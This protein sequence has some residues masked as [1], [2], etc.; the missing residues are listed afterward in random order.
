MAY[1]APTARRVAFGRTLGSPPP[2]GTPPPGP[3]VFTPLRIGEVPPGDPVPFPGSSRQF[4]ELRIDVPSG[5]AFA[6]VGATPSL[7]NIG[8]VYFPGVVDGNVAQI[9]QVFKNVADSPA[10]FT[11]VVT[12]L[13]GNTA[14]FSASF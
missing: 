1:A 13:A 4:Y 9:A 6:S 8:G 14:S 7:V 3:I 5:L 2:A 10:T 11:L 12:D